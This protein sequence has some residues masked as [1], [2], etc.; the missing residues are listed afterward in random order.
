MEAT[1]VGAEEAT[2]ARSRQA[3]VELEGTGVGEVEAGRGGVS[4]RTAA[5]TRSRQ[6]CAGVGAG[7]GRQE[8]PSSSCAAGAVEL[9][10]PRRTTRQTSSARDQECGS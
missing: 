6:C 1:D 4:W 5:A 2:A 3:A 7:E 10:S 9:G 8:R